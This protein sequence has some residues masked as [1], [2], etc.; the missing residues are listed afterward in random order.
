MKFVSAAVRLANSLQGPD[1]A[2]RHRPLDFQI[3]PAGKK[4]KT[5]R[6]VFFLATA[7]KKHVVNDGG[8]E[9]AEPRSDSL[10]VALDEEL[11]VELVH[12]VE[13]VV[14]VRPHHVLV[15][16]DLLLSGRRT[17]TKNK[18]KKNRGCQ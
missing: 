6:G 11:Q 3:I 8:G 7:T 15:V 5:K 12:G 17:R 4:K 16:V 13:D 14:A 1:V 10:F 9:G 2:S 18:R